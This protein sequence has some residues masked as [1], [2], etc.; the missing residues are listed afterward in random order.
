MLTSNDESTNLSQS[1][2]HRH[3]NSLLPNDP[4]LNGA[5][6][7]ISIRR[8][9][10]NESD[11]S[12]KS[13]KSDTLSQ[14]FQSSQSRKSSLMTGISHGRSQS[15]IP[16]ANETIHASNRLQNFLKSAGK[17][18][19]RGSSSIER[20][21]SLALA[22]LKFL[23]KKTKSVDFSN[24][25]N[26]IMNQL[27]ENDYAGDIEIQIGHDHEREQLVIR[28]IRAKNLLPKDTNGFSDPFVKIYLLPGR[29]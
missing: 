24:Q 1:L 10:S 22:S 7:N 5:G 23:K 28:I 29:E 18:Q 21:S 25:Q 12:D 11:E 16:I 6:K 4:G 3:R 26:I 27:R 2:S 17:R 14:Y 15:V 19:T 9:N 8:E 20:K 13:D